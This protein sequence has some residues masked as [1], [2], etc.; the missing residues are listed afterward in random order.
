MWTIDFETYS[1][2]GYQKI[3]GKWQ[4]IVKSKTGI[5][6]VGAWEY[7]KH[8]S[9]RVLSLCWKT[10]SGNRGFF[11][12][13]LP[14]SEKQIIEYVKYRG[15]IEAHNS[16][17]EW[18]IWNNVCSRLY[19]WPKLPLEQ[20][21]CS[22]AKARNW[23]LPGA[24]KDIGNA[25]KLSI[26]KNQRGEELIRK[27]SCPTGKI[28]K[29]ENKNVL[30][31]EMYAYNA[32]DVDAEEC[33]SKNVPDMSEHELA[34]WILDQHINARGVCVD[35]KSIKLLQDIVNTIKDSYDS[36]IDRL[37]NGEVKTIDQVKNIITF[38]N[39][40]GVTTKSIDKDHIK[41]LLL[42][43]INEICRRVLLVRKI[44]SGSAVK[45]LFSM[46]HKVSQEDSRI[47]G[48]YIYCGAERTGRFASLGVQLHNL[49]SG[50]GIDDIE[51]FIN[52]VHNQP[53]HEVIKKYPNIIETIAGAIRGLFIASE[54]CDLMG[55]D[56]SAIEA[57]V[58]ACLSGE[59]WRIEVFNGEGRIYE[60]SA[61][62]AFGM[63]M[64]EF[65]EYK[66]KTGEHHPLR[67][68]GKVRELANGYG[69]WVGAN[70]NFGAVGTDD[71]IKKDILAWRDESPN[72]VEFW[73][74]QWRKDKYRWE[75][76]HEYYGAEGSFI[77]AMLNPFVP[78]SFG[79]GN[80]ITYC[81]NPDTEVMNC[82]L[83]NGRRLI[84]HYPRLIPGKN[85]LNTKLDEYKIQFKFF[86]TDTSKG[87]YGWVTGYTYSGKL[88]ENITQATAAEILKDS[89][90]RVESVPCYDIVLH[91]HDEIVV[92][93]P[94]GLSSV[95]EFEKIVAIKSDWYSWWPIKVGGGW[96]GK[97]YRK[98]K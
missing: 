23:G 80:V 19:G 17:F 67:S 62:R 28:T 46:E 58:I 2:A 54:G 83:P 57:V 21:R 61:C 94:V 64:K 93:V 78:Y 20:L 27:L 5:S 36:E 87:P 30:M 41:K 84:Y 13:G 3:N 91:T 33:V 45:K 39:K 96:R 74:G 40:Q 66:E 38:L 76:S 6:I 69:G 49:K 25:R 73:G 10:D 7:S 89:M 81:Y 37:T 88:A 71:E 98:E 75:F 59:K 12:P 31:Q 35:L 70:R 97:R 43:D 8:P 15:L 52:Y 90:L 16:F 95:E 85:R 51:K 77:M 63:V 32:V 72:I 11:I 1:E 92:E 68:K 26:Q 79:F 48:H 9:T 65:D 86:N 82:E 56:F 22:A 14:E 60:E 4:A 34:V 53:K 24:L 18:C 47:R 55:T 50:M 42:S 44:A 29:K